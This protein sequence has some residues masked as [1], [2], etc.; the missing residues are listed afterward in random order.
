MILLLVA[1]IYYGNVYFL[2]ALANTATVYAVIYA[3]FKYTELVFLVRGEAIFW[4]YMFSC[5]AILYKLAIWIHS[6][7]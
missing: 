6:N 4:F 1:A 3:L 7:P 2:Q 5:S